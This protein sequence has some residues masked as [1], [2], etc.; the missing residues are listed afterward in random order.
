MLFEGFFDDE[1]K[2]LGVDNAAF[3]MF[4][5]QKYLER[6]KDHIEGF[7]AEV[8]WITRAFVCVY[9]FDLRTFSDYCFSIL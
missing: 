7:A 3:P 8:A 1:I 6:E 4:I 2:K 9:F 5:P